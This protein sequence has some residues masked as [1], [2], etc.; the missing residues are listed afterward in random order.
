MAF[1]NEFDDITTFDLRFTDNPKGAFAIFAKSYHSAAKLLAEDMLKRHFRVYEPYPVIFLYRHSIELYLKHY[2]Y[3]SEIISLI[4]GIEEE[5]HKLI[6]NHNLKDLFNKTVKIFSKQNILNINDFNNIAENVIKEFNE[7]DCNSFAFRYPIDKKGNSS[8][9]NI[10]YMNLK[11]IYNAIEELLN[12]FEAIEFGL[13][14]EKDKIIEAYDCQYVM[15]KVA[16]EFTIIRD[17]YESE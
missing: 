10:E 6:N 11:S 3:S 5:L 4:V 13:N 12:N 15:E 16:P 2:I 1:Y 7:I 14:I 17:E 8:I 9:S